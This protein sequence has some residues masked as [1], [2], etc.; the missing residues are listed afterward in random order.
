MH[1]TY[2]SR[3]NVSLMHEK[4]KPQQACLATAAAAEAAA[5][6]HADRTTHPSIVLVAKHNH[7]KHDVQIK[8]QHLKQAS[9]NCTAT[10]FALLDAEA[11]R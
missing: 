2:A 3:G 8:Q 10:G 6:L 4:K 11:F 5:Q 9:N 7:N 1:E